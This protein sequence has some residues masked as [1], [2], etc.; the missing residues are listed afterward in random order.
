MKHIVFPTYE[1]HPVNPGGAG[2]F[3]AGAVRAL[4][5]AGYRCTVLADFPPEEV[6][7]ARAH[8]EADRVRV[9]GV[10]ELASDEGLP[11]DLYL[12][13]SERFLRALASLAQ[14]API[15][16]IEFPEYAGMAFATLQARAQVGA[17]ARVPVALRIHGGFEFISRA[18]FEPPTLTSV[19]MHRLERAAIQM[20]DLLLGPSQSLC[21]LYRHAYGVDASRLVVSPPPMEILLDGLSRVERCP[22]PGHVLF[23]GK[24]QEVKGCDLLAEAAVSLVIDDP[25]RHWRFTFIGRDTTC[26]RHNCPF[27]VCLQK[28]IPAQLS[29]FFEFRSSIARHELPLFC[30]RPM[31]AVCPSRFEAFCLAAHEL[32]AL[33]VP[34]IVSDIPAFADWLNRDTGCLT[35]DGT[36]N[37]LKAK[38]ASLRNDTRLR[39]ALEASPG[40]RYPKFSAAYDRALARPAG[41][42][43]SSIE[44]W[45]LRQQI[46]NVA[47]G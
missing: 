10:H 11:D 29:I 30:R 34:L 36:A 41:L 39:E 32:R 21:E 35:F 46:G 47:T 37:D 44:K 26:A 43:R 28:T 25:K 42:E 33:G 7:R 1:L 16:L 27:S 6:E 38:L 13:K 4:A 19:A 20:A 12:A 9:V 15:D 14:Q 23:Y 8:F 17:L 2:V 24:L 18:E 3:I 5:R 45:Y 31:V 40:P 22:D